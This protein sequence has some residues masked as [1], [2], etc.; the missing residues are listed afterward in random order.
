MI[1]T[2]LIPGGA[3]AGLCPSHSIREPVSEWRATRLPSP[4]SRPLISIRSFDRRAA[5]RSGGN[6]AACRG[7]AAGTPGRE[8]AGGP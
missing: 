3:L 7:M 8:G 5:R 4:P 1:S 6:S 2:V